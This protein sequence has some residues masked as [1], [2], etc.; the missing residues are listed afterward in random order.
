MAT[1]VFFAAALL[2]GVS[3]LC[4]GQSASHN[5][6]SLIEQCSAVSTEEWDIDAAGDAGACLGWIKASMDWMG[7]LE[8]TLSDFAPE[9]PEDMPIRASRCFPEALTVGQAVDVL[10][11]Y[12]REHPEQQHF[13]PPVLFALAMSAAFC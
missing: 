7:Y 9:A 12:L 5:G 3:S 2:L 13:D 10:L 4:F 11:L 8:D 1:R 6:R